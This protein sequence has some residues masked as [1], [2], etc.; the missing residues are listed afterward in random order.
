MFVSIESVLTQLF[1]IM[2]HN[3]KWDLQNGTQNDY[4]NTQM[5]KFL[6]HKNLLN[7]GTRNMFF[8]AQNYANGT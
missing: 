2:K 8:G 1:N 4:F 3:I 7:F 6:V 5:M